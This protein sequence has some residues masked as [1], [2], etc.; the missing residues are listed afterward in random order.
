MLSSMKTHQYFVDL[1]RKELIIESV[2]RKNAIVTAN[3]AL[4]TWSN[5]I[6]TGRSP[7]DTYIVKDNSTNTTIDWES[8]NNVPMS[9]ELFQSLWNDANDM[10]DLKEDLYI[11]NRSIGAESKYALKVKTITDC[12]L[13]SLFTYNMFREINKIDL[14]TFADLEFELI[15][16]PADK[17]NLSRYS[18]LLHSDIVIATDF[19]KARGLV[20]GSSYMGSVKKLMFTTMNYLLPEKNVLPLHCSANVGK[21]NDTAFF[22]GLSG[23]GKTTLSTDEHRFLLGDD[24]HGW[25]ESGVFNMENGCYAKMTGIKAEKEPEIYNAVMHKDKFTNHGAIIENAMVYPNREVDYNDERL[26][27]NSRASYPLKFLKNIKDDSVSS[28]PQTIIFLTADANGVLPPVAKLDQNEAIFWYLMGYTSKI[29]GTERGI[30]EPKS[31]FSRFFGEPFMPRNPQDYIDLFIKY[32]K[33]YNTDVYLVNTGWTGGPYGVGS[34]FDITVTRHIISNI[35]D[36]TIKNENSIKDPIFQLSIPT[37]SK[38][39]PDILLNPVN[40][41]D[42][43]VLFYERAME[44]VRQFS[45]HFQNTYKGKVDKSLEKICPNY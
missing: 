24:E 15:V 41:W 30:K 5:E 6:S 21:N 27:P 35:L 9:P 16:L 7:E 29:A 14:S 1:P 13:T 11:S 26:T 43:K 45:N 33:K 31:V 40:S 37:K 36:G 17:I 23:T 10:L 8:P 38:G 20:L 42:D 44:L 2:K 19:S 25:S 28:H 34:R 39:V 4:A 18:G 22:L 12:P 3:G 32:L